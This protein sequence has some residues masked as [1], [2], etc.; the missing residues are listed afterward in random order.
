V[1]LNRKLSWSIFWAL[2]GVFVVI[3]GTMA[4]PAVG[5]LLM[6]LLFIIISGAVF[7]SLGVALIFL[8]VKERVGGTLMKFLILT[9]AS[10]AGFFVSAVLHNVF[11]G[12][13]IEISHIVVLSQSMEVLHVVF[14][15]L[16]IIVCPI[17]FLVGV[18]GSIVLAKRRYRMA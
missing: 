11:C 12:L 14:F 16:A 3:V 7:L 10:A 5:E 8:T 2:V 17:G 15:C 4:I 6:G 1:E 18:V 13:G 9:G